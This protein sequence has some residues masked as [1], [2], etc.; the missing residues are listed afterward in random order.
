MA[1]IDKSKTMWETPSHRF[2][3]FVPCGKHP[4]FSFVNIGPKRPNIGCGKHALN[5]R[6]YDPAATPPIPSPSLTLYYER[7]AFSATSLLQLKVPVHP[8]SPNLIASLT[9]DSDSS[10]SLNLRKH[11][12][13]QSMMAT[14][15]LVLLAVPFEV[16]TQPQVD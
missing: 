15:K 1:N 13:V 14:G 4:I 3:K 5:D 2:E 11:L 12:P 16:H 9:L 8:P 10:S 7:R 6:S